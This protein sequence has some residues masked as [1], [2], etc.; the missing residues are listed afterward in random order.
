MRFIHRIDALKSRAEVVQTDREAL[1]RASFLDGRETFWSARETRGVEDL[2]KLRE[3]QG[4][5]RV[6]GWIFHVGF[7]GSTLLSHLLDQNGE[8]LAL[9]EPQALVDLA[10]QAPQLRALGRARSVKGWLETLD[11][12]FGGLGDALGQEVVVKASNWANPLLA[13]MAEADMLDKAIYVTMER[14]AWMRACIR[15]GRER[16]AWVARCVQHTA[17]VEPEVARLMPLVVNGVRDPLDQII[18]LAALLD[19]AQHRT[20]ARHDPRA[21]RRIDYATI[22]DDP[23]RA[24]VRARDL[25]GL[26]QRAD[27]VEP[28]G[29]HAKDPARAFDARQRALEDRQ[30]ERAHG[31]RIDAALEWIDAQAGSSQ[32]GRRRA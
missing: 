14:R 19:W 24:I 31:A 32:S 17:Q 21:L 28:L 30:V 7:C 4:S 5:C 27:P 9:R 1:R 26:P 6:R 8:L 10:D 16:L 20:I 25:L 23:T 13:Y 2:A 22:V 11:T 18:R 15:G 3:A 12:H 29:H